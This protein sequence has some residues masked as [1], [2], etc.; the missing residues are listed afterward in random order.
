M[1]VNISIYYMY[2][3]ISNPHKSSL[4]SLIILK[5]VKESR[6]QNFRNSNTAIPN[7]IRKNSF[8]SSFMFTV[9]SRRERGNLV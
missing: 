5:R 4:G 6:D 2:V 8:N 9:K 3:F 7:L 1:A